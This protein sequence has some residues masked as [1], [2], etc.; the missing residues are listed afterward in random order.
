MVPAARVTSTQTP[1][2]C[3]DEYGALHL[4]GFALT[5]NTDVPEL[6]LYHLTDANMKQYRNIN[7]L[8]PIEVKINGKSS[9]AYIAQYKVNVPNDSLTIIIYQ[10]LSHGDTITF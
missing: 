6:P 2:V 7:R 4:S 3:I 9:I 5:V 8:L 1:T 10:Q